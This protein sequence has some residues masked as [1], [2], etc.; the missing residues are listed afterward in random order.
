ME[1]IRKEIENYIKE[2]EEDNERRLKD[3][4]DLNAR[5]KKGIL[6]MDR[7][8]NVRDSKDQLLS[9][10]EKRTIGVGGRGWHALHGNK[11]G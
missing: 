5:I 2:K 1:S 3:G 7:E 6:H 10:R 4:E 8:Y 11:T 9:K